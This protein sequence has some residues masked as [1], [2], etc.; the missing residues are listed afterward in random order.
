MTDIDDIERSHKSDMSDPALIG[1]ND[2]G[3]LERESALITKVRELAAWR[4]EAEGHM[5]ECGKTAVQL[6]DARDK[7]KTMEK[8]NAGLVEA[9]KRVKNRAFEIYP[10]LEPSSVQP[11]LDEIDGI[12]E[13]ALKQYGG[14]HE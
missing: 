14:E 1:A 6:A 2:C 7:I 11:S 13:E 12:A 3:L 9:L 10:T 5:V 4:S 8:D